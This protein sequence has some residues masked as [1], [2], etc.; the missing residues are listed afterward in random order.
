MRYNGNTKVLVPWFDPGTG[1]KNWM[2]FSFRGDMDSRRL[3]R[4]VRKHIHNNLGRKVS[5]KWIQ[6][7]C[8]IE[9]E[10]LHD[11][12]V[13]AIVEGFINRIEYNEDEILADTDSQ[14]E[15]TGEA[16]EPLCAVQD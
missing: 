4:E 9:S 12:K 7:N 16:E 8:L 5:K 2:V 3:F 14:E 1:D 10:T 15:T 13:D 6:R 11:D